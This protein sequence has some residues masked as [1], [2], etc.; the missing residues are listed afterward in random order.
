MITSLW[1]KALTNPTR[2]YYLT[3]LAIVFD[4]TLLSDS[5]INKATIFF[6]R[7]SCHIQVH[8]S[9][10]LHPRSDATSEPCK[11]VFHSSHLSR[12]MSYGGA[13]TLWVFHSSTAE[14]LLFNSVFHNGVTP[15]SVSTLK[16][17]LGV[18]GVLPLKPQASPIISVCI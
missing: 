4:S 10:K 15:V 6:Q 5:R 3:Y 13:A 11:P 1:L 7:Y 14:I 12:N 9:R 17:L 16:P 2:A 18:I 8:L